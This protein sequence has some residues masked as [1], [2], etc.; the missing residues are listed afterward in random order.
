[1]DTARLRE[2][3]GTGLIAS[4]ALNAQRHYR[5]AKPSE[6][7]SCSRPNSRRPS[8]LKTASDLGTALSPSMLAHADEVIVGSPAFSSAT[9]CRSPTLPRFSSI[10]GARP[11]HRIR[12]LLPSIGNVCVLV[13]AA[14]WL[15]ML[16]LQLSNRRLACILGVS[17]DL[18]AKSFFN[19]AFEILGPRA[20]RVSPIPICPSAIVI[21][22]RLLLVT[23]VCR[24]S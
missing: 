14:R 16:L 1:M 2:P 8:I 21:P 6:L 17:S 20:A 7:R 24:Q 13:F 19:P 22:D 3:I 9:A 10:Q 12:L 4:V 11:S 23:T 5:G 18:V 15:P